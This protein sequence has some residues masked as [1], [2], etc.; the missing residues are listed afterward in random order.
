MNSSTN[1]VYA[2]MIITITFAALDVQNYN[3]ID[4]QTD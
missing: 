3:Y 2:D 1:A 4:M